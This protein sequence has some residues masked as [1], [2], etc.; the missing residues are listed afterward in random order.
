M[1]QWL[2]NPTRNHEGSIPALAFLGIVD[3]V[4]VVYNP[5]GIDVYAYTVFLAMNVPLTFVEFVFVY[6]NAINCIS[7]SIGRGGK[8]IFLLVGCGLV[9]YVFDI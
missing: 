2:T 3:V 5:I 7:T 4:T 1:A 6:A 9:L 8:V